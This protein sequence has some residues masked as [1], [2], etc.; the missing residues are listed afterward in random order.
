MDLL[1]DVGFAFLIVGAA[2]VVFNRAIGVGF[3]RV[4]KR[5]WRNSP[6]DPGK[7]LLE[8]IYDEQRAPRIMRLLGIVLILQGV[9]FILPW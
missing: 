7:R 6:I 8:R 3:C 2:M 4:G 1:Q 9:F 5:A